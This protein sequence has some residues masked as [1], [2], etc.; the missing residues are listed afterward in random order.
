MPTRFEFTRNNKAPLPEMTSLCE[1]TKQ[2]ATVVH[3][4]MSTAK[5]YRK[6]RRKNQPYHYYEQKM[7]QA[8]SKSEQSVFYFHSL[9]EP[10]HT[11]HLHIKNTNCCPYSKVQTRQILS[12]SS[13]TQQF[14]ILNQYR[15]YETSQM[16]GTQS[17][18]Y[19]E[20]NIKHRQKPSSKT[21]SRRADSHAE[22]ATEHV[23]VR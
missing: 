22:R 19:A 20:L 9:A 18:H 7:N 2:S 21:T 10:L 17:Q 13:D 8:G 16:L 12:C 1:F 3:R 11:L 15:S 5:L 14:L 6:I 4:K 23:Y